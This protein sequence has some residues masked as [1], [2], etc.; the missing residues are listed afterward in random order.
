V[1]SASLRG[2][3]KSLSSNHRGSHGL[4]AKQPKPEAQD[5]FIDEHVFASGMKTDLPLSPMVIA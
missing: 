2:F 1:L 4:E 3:K 5:D